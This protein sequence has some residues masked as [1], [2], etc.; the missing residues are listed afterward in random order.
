MRCDVCMV[1]AGESVGETRDASAGAADGMGIMGGNLMIIFPATSEEE[2]E[3]K[4]EEERRQRKHRGG[5]LLW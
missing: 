3:G 5:I 4:G 2:G 1:R